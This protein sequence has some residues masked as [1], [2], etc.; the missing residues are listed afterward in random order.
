MTHSPLTNGIQLTSDSDARNR[1]VDR[2]IV[3]HAATTSLAAILALFQPGGRTVSANYALGN[4]GTLIL[5]VDENRRAWTSSSAAW[6]GR[7]VTIEVA[8]SY[9]GDPW[10]VSDA[11]FDKLARLIADVATR[12]G[13]PINDDTVLTHQELY[14][15]YGDS[16]PTACPGDLQRRKAQL[17]A[18]ANHY[19]SGGGA[20]PPARKGKTMYLAADTGNTIWLY[21][22]NGR[23]G[24]SS[25]EHVN[26]FNRLLY[27]KT[28]YDTFN[29]IEAGIMQGY[30][31]Q[32]G[33]SGSDA[34]LS[35]LT[36]AI[37]EVG[38]PDSAMI[39]QAVR[40]GLSGASVNA[41]VTD[42]TVTAI[43]NRVLDLNRERL[44]S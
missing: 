7:A 8:N 39:A 2:F 15:R 14:N 35:A 36:K 18:L 16:Y 25:M 24:L 6:D 22:D 12:Y 20:T 38:A 19:K 26:L 13:F 43:A 34:E 1:G 3:H 28:P 37:S 17:L 10:P 40:E 33:N 30:I 9:A 27:G 4:D 42:A 5:A 44:E 29:T 41:E 11:A 23:V 31:L 32:A 21:T